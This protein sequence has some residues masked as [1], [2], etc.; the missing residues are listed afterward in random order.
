MK[1]HKITSCILTGVLFLAV[2]LTW[3]TTWMAMKIALTSVPP[4]F[5]TGLRFLIAAPV[6]ITMAKWS[7]KPL[8]FPRGKR[9]FQ[10]VL[11]LFYFAVPFTLMI[12]GEE[13]VSSGMASLLFSV[14]PVAIVISSWFFLGHVITRVQLAGMAIVML[15]LGVIIIQESGTTEIESWKGVVAILMAV[16]LHA[17]VYVQ[18]K[19]YCAGI[20]VLTYN[21]LPCLGA[22]VLLM[23]CGVFYEQVNVATMGTRSLFAIV[24]LGIVAGVLGIMAYFQL[25]KRVVPFYASLVYFIFP[26][27]AI[28]LEDVVTQQ[29]MSMGSALMIIPFMSGIVIVL[30]PIWARSSAVN[31]KI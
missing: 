15:A 7:G 23:G 10:V 12:Y 26:L 9:R 24:Y 4:V 14:M 13:T 3:G 20:S 5:A 16:A 22:A 25:Q 29:P 21:A 31:M 28:A 27:I 1:E 8:V 6:L 17:V 2:S 11:S 19:K 30:Y 18:C